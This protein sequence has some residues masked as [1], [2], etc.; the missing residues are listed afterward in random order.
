MMTAL[1]LLQKWFRAYLRLVKDY[2]EILNKIDISYETVQGRFPRRL[3]FQFDG[4]YFDFVSPGTIPVLHIYWE[5]FRELNYTAPFGTARTCFGDNRIVIDLGANI[6]FFS[7]LA[8]A[9]GSKVFAVEANPCNYYYLLRNIRKNSSGQIIAF[10]YSIGSRSGFRDLFV[11]DQWSGSSLIQAQSIGSEFSIVTRG[12][13]FRDLM[14]E[15]GN[16]KVDLLK[17]DCEGCESEIIMNADVDVFRSIRR[18]SLE[19][20]DGTADYSALRRKLEDLGFKILDT[21]DRI[22]NYG[23]LRAER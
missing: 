10:N 7:I 2:P 4:R 6:G 20:H 8:G 19:Y 13:S 22:G 12:R 18:I 5:I 14:E 16:P 17:M 11:A 21:D 9:Y 1:N 3:R 23:Y 15:I